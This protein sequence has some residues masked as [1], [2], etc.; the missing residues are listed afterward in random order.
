MTRMS[1]DD[2]EHS[3]YKVFID[4]KDISATCIRFD[5]IEGWAILRGGERLTG[6]VK[7]TP[8]PRLPLRTGRRFGDAYGSHIPIL[9]GL[10]RLFEIKQ[11]AEFG[12]GF[13][14][15]LTFLNRD[16]FP[17]LESLTSFDD[18]QLWIDK[19]ISVT[20]ERAQFLL[21]LPEV[22]LGDYDLVFVDDSATRRPATIRRVV[23]SGADSIF[24]FHDTEDRNYRNPIQGFGNLFTFKVFSP[25]T[26]VSIDFCN[27]FEKLN[28][29]ILWHNH[30]VP[31][32]TNAWIKAF[33]DFDNFKPA[34]CERCGV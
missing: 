29:F 15:T 2:P 5:D 33:E 24:V 9:I 6:N 34:K 11:V 4:G 25:F 16:A 23:S 30:I 20:D 3:V 14:S 21:D 17:M 18:S 1:R 12:C 8:P 27:D 7:L 22:D 19:L 13:Y 32:D 10:A 26:S 31:T 28:N